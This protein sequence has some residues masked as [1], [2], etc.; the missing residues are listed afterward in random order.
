[1][2]SVYFYS[3]KPDGS[4]A[5]EGRPLVMVDNGKP[6][7]INDPWQQAG[8]EQAGDGIYSLTI[9]IDNS[10]QPGRYIFTFYMRD[11]AG[12]LS[13]SMVDSIEVVP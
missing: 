13:N 3:K 12:N 11:K 8:D 5:N 9:L 6:F 10:A 2:D 1:V 7:N 4:L